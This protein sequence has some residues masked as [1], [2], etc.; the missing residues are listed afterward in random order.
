MT[1]VFLVEEQS[2]KVFL[3]IILPRVLPSGVDFITVP[4]S[5]GG[6]PSTG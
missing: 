2:M 3:D 1:I 5:R 4:Q 6:P